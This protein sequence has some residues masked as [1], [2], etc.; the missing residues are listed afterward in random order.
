MS[1][2]I[3][4]NQ[5]YSSIAD[6]IRTKLGT[7]EAFLPAQMASAIM[8]ISGGGGITPSGT[9]SVSSNGTFDIT[10]YASVD[11]NVP[12]HPY[13]AKY[14]D[15]A[16]FT[17]FT[18]TSITTIP[19]GAFA[20]TL[21]LAS[22]SFPAATTI[23]SYAFAY[24]YKFSR[25]SFPLVKTISAY[26]FQYCSSFYSGLS[27]TSAIFPSL[28]GTLGAYT[29][30]GCQYLT[31]VDLPNI[32][33]VG[34]QAFSGCSRIK[35][36]NL[37]KVTVVSAGAFSYLTVCTDYSLPLLKKIGSSAFYSNWALTTL[38]LPS[39]AVISGYAF[40][41]CSKLMSLYL[42]G[43]SVPTLTATAFVNMPMSVSVNN[44]YG[45]IYVPSSLYAS[46]IV[47]TNWASYSAR[48]VSIT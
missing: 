26:A 38:T 14:T 29:F 25:A 31:G 33:S 12:E 16:N 46:Y 13:A 3:T 43:S 45:S 35:N 18:D 11:V 47:A 36:V 28:S 6:A 23:G 10:S 27:L 24:C 48:I 8:S 17:T 20:L 21:N 40:R 4:D 5:H 41:Y 39:A 30:R 9:Y 37:P 32:T 22:V 42:T 2:I 34:A 19:Y 44:V 15:N 1:L 7:N